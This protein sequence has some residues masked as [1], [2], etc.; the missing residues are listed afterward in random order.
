VSKLPEPQPND[1]EGK[2][3]IHAAVEIAFVLRAIMKSGALVTTYFGS[4]S[5]F[6]VTA[7]LEVDADAGLIIMDSGSN[8]ALNERLMR[9]QSLTVVSS[10]DGVKIE[11]AVEKVDAASFEGRLAFRIPFPDS[12]LK[13]QRREYYRL[14]V[15]VL[16]PLRCQIPLPAGGYIDTTIGDISLGGI[17]LMGEY[18]GL[19][20]EP[21]RSFKGCRIQL[22]EVGT[23]NTELAVRNSFPMTLRSGAV[24]R[25]TGCAF[26]HLPAS[27]EAMLQRYIIRLERD[28][29]AKSGEP[30]S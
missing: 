11:F 9:S 24:I 4:G 30:K 19:Q 7:L 16:N 15:P 25:R 21:G 1:E 14:T 23:I 28:R 6:I 12:L 8:P 20:L 18:A 2:Y 26:V 13:L 22:P 3:R 10:Q 17:S 5:D 27:Q 29:R